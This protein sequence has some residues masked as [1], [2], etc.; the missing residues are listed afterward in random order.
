MFMHSIEYKYAPNH[1]TTHG[2]KT[3]NVILVMFYAMKIII[4]GPT[5]D[6]NN[7]KGYLCPGAPATMPH[8]SHIIH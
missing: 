8:T 3:L 6:L 7:L 1:L 2:K 4:F 5:P